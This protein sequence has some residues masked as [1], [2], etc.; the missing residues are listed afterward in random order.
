MTIEEKIG[1]RPVFVL[2]QGPSLNTLEKN[3]EIFRG[4]D[5]CYI[6]VNRFDAMEPIL[7]KINKK[8]DMVIMAD[9]QHVSAA[10]GQIKKF[11][12]RGD[13]SIWI[14]GKDGSNI[15]QLGYSS[16]PNNAYL[17]DSVFDSNPDCPQTLAVLIDVL[18]NANTAKVFLFGCDGGV[19]QGEDFYNR[20]TVAYY[21]DAKGMEKDN[22]RLNN[23]FWNIRGTSTATKIYNCCEHSKLNAFTKINPLEF[24]KYL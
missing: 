20:D 15:S 11:L 1:N 12:Q 6:A 4:L 10:S 22:E 3:I 17:N 7:H 18:I 14:C 21:S 9:L 2:A 23:N 5:C 24:K 13:D 19:H 16:A 8:F